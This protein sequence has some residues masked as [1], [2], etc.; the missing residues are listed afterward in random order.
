MDGLVL[1]IQYKVTES[2]NPIY[3][4]RIDCPLEQRSYELKIPLFFH[5]STWTTPL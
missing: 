5:Y 2:A 3:C 4:T 1:G